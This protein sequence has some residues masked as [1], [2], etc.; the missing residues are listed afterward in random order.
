MKAV[1]FGDGFTEIR[2]SPILLQNGGGAVSCVDG[3]GGQLRL[4]VPDQGKLLFQVAPFIACSPRVVVV[5]V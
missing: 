3:K 5:V 1:K 4:D 2:I